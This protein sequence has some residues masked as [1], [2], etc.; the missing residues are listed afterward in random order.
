MTRFALLTSVL[1][2]LVVAATPAASQSSIVGTVY[3]SLSIH[4]PLP[5]AMVVLVERSRY[6]T[7][8]ASGRFRFEDLPA[9]RYSLGLLHAV[10]D[11]FDLVAP[12]QVVEVANGTNTIVALAT[13]SAVSAYTLGCAARLSQ[14]ARKADVVA[15]L[16]IR[17]TE[18]LSAWKQGGLLHPDLL[19]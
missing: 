2:L 9:G 19:H 15:Y 6:A 4:G 18:H 16:K 17:T 10:L 5:G 7:A 14:V 13:P 1:R 12:L 8:D 11:S 3:D